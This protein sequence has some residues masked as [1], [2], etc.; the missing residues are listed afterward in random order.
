M[1]PWTTEQ[2]PGDSTSA[3]AKLTKTV[4][5]NACRPA[6]MT[7]P[8]YSLSKRQALTARGIL[9]R[10]KGGSDVMQ[11]IDTML[12][13]S[14]CGA[15]FTFTAGEQAYF[16]S[17]DLSEPRRCP[18]CRATRRGASA[19]RASAGDIDQHEP[20]ALSARPMFTAT[21]DAC[22]QA[23]QVPSPPRPDRPVYCASCFRTQR[24]A[25][26]RRG[27]CDTVGVPTNHC[28]TPRTF[29]PSRPC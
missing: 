9:R 8:G 23:T 25:P 18:A 4:K 12:T 7:A 19:E 15:S 29:P 5:P 26:A 3:H 14:D 1:V 20:R 10:G 16:A 2:N 13:C 11:F 21:C 22:G 24:P 28:T 27:Y 17:H 6:N